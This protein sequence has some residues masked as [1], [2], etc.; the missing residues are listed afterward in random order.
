MPTQLLTEA[1]ARACGPVSAPAVRQTLA[2]LRDMPPTGAAGLDA[3]LRDPG[4]AV[5][6]VDF[7]GTLA[8]IVADPRDARLR[9]DAARA[10]TALADRLRRIVIVTGRP[11]RDLVGPGGL[12]EHG[13]RER[14]SILGMYG[15]E[16]WDPATG[17]LHAPDPTPELVRLKA[18]LPLFV[19]ELTCDAG[20]RVE[21]K[22]AAVA[23][24]MRRAADPHAAFAL[25]HDPLLKLA[26]EHGVRA[27]PGRFVVELR[28]EGGDKGTALHG[29]LTEHR[30]RA[31]LYAGDDRGDV[32]AYDT[33]EQRRR[34]GLPGTLVYSAPRGRD[35][36]VGELERRADA[37]VPG[38]AG[39]AALLALLAGAVGSGARG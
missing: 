3:L 11:V 20:V 33:V 22:G 29:F 38:P 10:L 19:R 4:S 17:R 25:L 2:S 9:P 8:D 18:V 28:P 21:D 13:I 24:H 14:V 36:R 1:A 31:V 30:A 6:A 27:E 37:A 16:R 26:A 7:D 34:A 35:E 23:V 32:P 39:V 15:D 12:L 5:L